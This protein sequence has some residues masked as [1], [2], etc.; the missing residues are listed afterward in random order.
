MVKNPY[1]LL[2][3]FLVGYEFCDDLFQSHIAL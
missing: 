1:A 3:I 2:I